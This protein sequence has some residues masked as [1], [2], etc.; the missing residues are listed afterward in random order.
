MTLTIELPDNLE[1]AL[2][3]Q[4]NAQGVSEEGYVRRVLERDL[5]TPAHTPLTRS[6]VA[7]ERI[8]ELRKGNFLHG[9][10]IKELIEEGRE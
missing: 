4:A 6:Q 9:V 3:A 8:R 10:P 2:R 7:G 5:A 1:A